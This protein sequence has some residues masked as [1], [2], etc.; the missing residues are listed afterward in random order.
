MGKSCHHQS[1]CFQSSG[2]ESPPRNEMKMISRL[3]TLREIQMG[4]LSRGRNGRTDPSTLS[5]SRLFFGGLSRHSTFA[6]AGL[7]WFWITNIYLIDAYGSRIGRRGLWSWMD[8]TH[9]RIRSRPVSTFQSLPATEYVIPSTL[10]S[11]RSKTRD[12]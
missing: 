12:Q 10:C 3:W 11:D 6:R 8:S 4:L 2:L 9:S 5:R 1:N 7:D